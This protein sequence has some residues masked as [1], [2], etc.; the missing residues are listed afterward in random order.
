ML[1]KN[2]TMIKSVNV[3]YGGANNVSM[4]VLTKGTG[5]FILRK[6]II[7]KDGYTPFHNHDWEHEVYVLSGNGLLKTMKG[8]K[9]LKGGD[10]VFIKP[11]EWHQ[12]LNKSRK[13]FEF[14]CIIPGEK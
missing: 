9:K 2:S 14:L 5:K 4:K 11:R 8:N 12:F 7:K 10:V 13:D 3:S 6:F 1:V